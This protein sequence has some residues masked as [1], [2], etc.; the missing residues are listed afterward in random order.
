VPLYFYLKRNKKQLKRFV[1][2]AIV[3]YFS[4]EALSFSLSLSAILENYTLA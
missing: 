1:N 4:R 2:I 3:T